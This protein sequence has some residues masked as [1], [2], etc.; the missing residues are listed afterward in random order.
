MQTLDCRN[1]KELLDSYLSDEL[2]V[3]TNHKV[4]RHLEQCPACRGE[5]A[6][7]RDLR[8]TMQRAGRQLQFSAAAGAR[9][10]ECLRA[11]TADV[12]PQAET[13]AAAGQT[14]HR[15]S[16]FSRLLASVSGVWSGSRFPLPVAAA[17]MALLAFGL[18]IFLFQP[19]S[20]SAAQL[21][22]SLWHEVVNDH[23]YCSPHF[24]HEETPLIKE[25][26][27][28]AYNPAY[29]G[30]DRIAE[31]GAQ[32]LRLRTVHICGFANRRFAHLVYTRE[33]ELISLL[34]TERNSPAMKNGVV[35]ADNGLAAGLQSA[36]QEGFSASAYQTQK[37]IVLVVTKLSEPETKMLAEKIALPV[38]NHL[39]HLEAEAK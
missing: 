19:R 34:V 13:V 23:D 33:D 31:V 38:S 12:L 4:L 1:L 20:A 36:I 37:H 26:V 32:G 9:L 16:F 25:D 18:G 35:P 14:V 3:E 11:E 39:R 22:Q 24:R 15:A 30:L 5:L 8:E 27:L 17:V 7:R 29:V 6:A 21:S 28:Q 2:S 10:R